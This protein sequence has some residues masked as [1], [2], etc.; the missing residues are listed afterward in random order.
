MAL[1][2]TAGELRDRIRAQ[3]RASSPNVGGVVRREWRDTTLARRARIVGRIGGETA[4]AG[5]LDGSQP[6]EVTV[7]SDAGTR[8]LTADHR[9]VGLAGPHAGGVWA[10]R[11]VT[12][13]GA[14]GEWLLFT[15]V[16][17][18]PGDGD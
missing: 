6:V 18:G 12:V 4:L 16:A 9:F 14:R 7:R 17:G 2:P 15:C 10:I 5:R 13:I 11:S 8:A 1:V 3:V